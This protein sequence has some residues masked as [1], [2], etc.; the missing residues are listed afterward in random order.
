[1]IRVSRNKFMRKHSLRRPSALPVR[2]RLETQPYD[3]N[4]WQDCAKVTA[5]RP[6]HIPTAPSS[7]DP[8]ERFTSLWQEHVPH[9]GRRPP[10]KGVANFRGSTTDADRRE[11][12]LESTLEQAASTISLGNR[13]VARLQ[14]QVGPVCHLDENGEEK[15]PIF[16]FV[17]TGTSGE[18]L[19]VAVKP[20]R[21]RE[22]SGIDDTV[23]AVR[24]QRPEFAS[25]V[26]VWTEQQLPRHAEHNAGLI[27]RSRRLRN[28]PDVTA[29][30]KVARLT[31]G[32]FHLGYLLRKHGADA[33][34]F[35]AAV[36]LIDD[37]VLVPVE[38]GRIRPELRVRFAA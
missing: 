23:A 18:T 8:E 1:M 33:R 26:A 36:N 6:D 35:T 22:S 20:G 4:G 15:R 37:G 27:L 5:T 25:E 3:L 7:N 32:A 28:E 24:N 10:Q 29:M 31:R 16:D 19:A 34:G 17:S 11:I 9:A 38:H 21:R 14:S 12:V 30:H 13:L 2:P